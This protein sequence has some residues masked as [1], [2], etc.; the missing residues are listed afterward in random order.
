MFGNTALRAKPRSGVADRRL[1]PS[2]S[3]EHEAHRRRKGE[4]TDLLDEMLRSKL[5]HV[6]WLHP[7]G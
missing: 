1:D 5:I 4:M 7:G 2:L 3:F 6:L